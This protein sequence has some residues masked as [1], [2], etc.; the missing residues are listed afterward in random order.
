V[1]ASSSC[2]MLM[3]LLIQKPMRDANGFSHAAPKNLE[4]CPSGLRL[5]CSPP[6]PGRPGKKKNSKHAAYK[7]NNPLLRVSTS[8]DRLPKLRDLPVF[9]FALTAA[10]SYTPPD[11]RHFRSWPLP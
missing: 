10:S 3:N 6:L 8:W 5:R 1:A 11:A 2:R 4:N 9:S 7:A